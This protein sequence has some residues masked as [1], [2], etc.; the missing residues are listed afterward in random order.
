MIRFGQI[1][2]T[3]RLMLSWILHRRPWSRKLRYCCMI[4]RYW[5]IILISQHHWLSNI[6]DA[7]YIIPALANISSSHSNVPCS[8]Y[9]RCRSACC[10][11][12]TTSTIRAC[13]LSRCSPASGGSK[14]AS[15]CNVAFISSASVVMPKLRQVNYWL[16]KTIQWWVDWIEPASSIL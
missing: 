16:L 13:S 3:D 7:R 14:A 9:I 12:R 1:F 5:M 6:A 2:A 4:L 15:E 11:Q 8:W 10:R